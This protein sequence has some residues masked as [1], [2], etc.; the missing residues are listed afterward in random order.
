M[1][2]F[3][4]IPSK[5]AKA[6]K[7]LTKNLNISDQF[8]KINDLYQDFLTFYNKKYKFV[9]EYGFKNL[10]TEQ[11]FKGLEKLNKSIKR[12]LSVLKFCSLNT[13]IQKLAEDASIY[14]KRNF[15]TCVIITYLHIWKS[16]RNKTI[17][18]VYDEWTRLK[19]CSYYFETIDGEF[20]YFNK[21]NIWFKIRKENILNL[22]DKSKWLR[23]INFKVFWLR[24]ILCIG[25]FFWFYIA[26]MTNVKEVMKH[27]QKNIR[28]NNRSMA[29]WQ[30]AVCKKIYIFSIHAF[31]Q[32][33]FVTVFW[34]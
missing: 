34:W 15:P 9:K 28:S 27:G 16:K 1:S 18:Y 7:N 12:I 22:N 4:L 14:I 8:K 11:K 17:K 13:I 32:K 26:N 24:I 6:Y 10:K 20:E 21:T 33:S 23:E 3:K 29:S 30:E 5:S 2:Y 25:F 31:S 19:N